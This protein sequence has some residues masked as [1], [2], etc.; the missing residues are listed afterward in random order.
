MVSVSR[1]AA[2]SPPHETKRFELRGAL[3]AEAAAAADPERGHRRPQPHVRRIGSP[4]NLPRFCRHFSVTLLRR[5]WGISI[6]SSLHIH[7][8]NRAAMLKCSH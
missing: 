8:D 5:W 1:L 4:S 3:W 7:T 6:W 2:V